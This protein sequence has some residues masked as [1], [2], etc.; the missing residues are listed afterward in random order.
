MQVV[1]C[2]IN[3]GVVIDHDIYF[4]DIVSDTLLVFEGD[5]LVG[6]IDN[7]NIV[8]FLMIAQTEATQG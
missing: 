6:Y 1:S 2:R 3:E 7:E 8:E 5:R 4:I